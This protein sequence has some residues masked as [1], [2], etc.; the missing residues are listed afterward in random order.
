MDYFRKSMGKPELI[1]F[2]LTDRCELT[3]LAFIAGG[4]DSTDT[5]HSFDAWP[6]LKGHSESIP[7]KRI[8][9]HALYQKRQCDACAI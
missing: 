2:D 5:R 8:R 1:D 4:V 3:R 9:L 6:A 7:A